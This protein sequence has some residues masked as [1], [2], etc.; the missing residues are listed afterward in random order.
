MKKNEELPLLIQRHKIMY[1]LK[2]EEVIC[3]IEEFGVVVNGRQIVLSENATTLSVCDTKF[4]IRRFMA[5]ILN[6]DSVICRYEKTPEKMFLLGARLAS[7]GLNARE[8]TIFCN[9]LKAF[10][11]VPIEENEI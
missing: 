2:L 7:L 3:K 5:S 9:A 6:N 10:P 8:Q 4:A 11:L 1:Q